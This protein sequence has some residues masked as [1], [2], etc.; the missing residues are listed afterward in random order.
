[1]MGKYLGTIFGESPLFIYLESLF[2]LS[3][4]VMVT[5]LLIPLF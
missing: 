5:V 1:M 2:A 3:I 4:L